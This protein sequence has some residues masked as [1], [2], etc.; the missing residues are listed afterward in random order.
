MSFI[1]NAFVTLSHKQLG[2]DWQNVNKRKF[3]QSEEVIRIYYSNEERIFFGMM[4]DNHNI[5]TFSGTFKEIYDIALSVFKNNE[6]L[7][8]Q[9]VY[10]LTYPKKKLD[11]MNIV[12]SNTT[13]LDSL[14]SYLLLLI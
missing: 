6:C 14:K 5:T 9:F 4:A 12:L 3:V 10:P 13:T 1:D 11:L 8:L 2:Y 7:D